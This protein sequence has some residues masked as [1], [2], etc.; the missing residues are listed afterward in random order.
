MTVLGACQRFLGLFAAASLTACTPAAPPLPSYRYRLTVDVDTPEGVK[1]GSS[2]IA[3]ST[4]MAGRDALPTPGAISHQVAGEA[5]AVDLGSRGTLFALLRSDSNSDWASNVLFRLTPAP[6]SRRQPGEPFDAQAQFTAHYAAML[7]RRDRIVLPP[8]FP[9]AG[10]LADDPARP[11]LVRFRRLEDPA[12][13]ERVDPANLAAAFGAG[14]T[15]RQIT[16]QLTD[17]PV[18]TGL[19]ARLPW[20]AQ[21]RGSLVPVQPGQTKAAMPIGADLSEAD[22]TRSA[23]Q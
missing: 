12:S 8:V 6:P 7:Q 20:L 13:V 3:V 18:T 14:V 17:D 19:A 4:R 10:H 2:V 15:L 22:F 1:T 11:M 21:Q 23:A 9:A 16:V 5:V